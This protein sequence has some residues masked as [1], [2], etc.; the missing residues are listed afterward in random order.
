MRKLRFR[1]AQKLTSGHRSNKRWSGEF[2][3][4]LF[5]PKASSH[6]FFYSFIQC[7]LCAGNWD[8]EMNCQML[9]A[10]RKHYRRSWEPRD[11]LEEGS[12]SRVLRDV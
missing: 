12:L 3:P 2:N 1:E 4:H 9:L 10:C 7:L 6:S 11:F 5:D 8:M